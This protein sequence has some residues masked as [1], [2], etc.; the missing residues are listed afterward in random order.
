MTEGNAIAAREAGEADLAGRTREWSAPWLVELY[1][2]DV[3]G[4]GDMAVAASILR[5]H[6]YVVAYQMVDEGQMVVTFAPGQ[7]AAGLADL[8][9]AAAALH[10]RPPTLIRP[11]SGKR[12][13]DANLAWA[14]EA[15][16]LATYGYIPISQTWV[17]G[18][19]GLAQVGLGFLLAPVLTLV[20]ILLNRSRA[21]RD[22]SLAVTY[23][24]RDGG[25]PSSL[26]GGIDVAAQIA[27]LRWEPMLDARPSPAT[28]WW[29]ERPGWQRMAI[30]GGVAALALGVLLAVTYALFAAGVW[31]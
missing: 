12:Q 4:R 29:R 18:N 6:G 22:G 21:D 19:R 16:E 25:R 14:A 3:A 17:P 31:R 23:E 9:Y 8:D 10:G 1:P 13:S 11:Y 24:L 26:S 20:P 27:G 30:F 5:D 15:A 28:G 7:S 2:D